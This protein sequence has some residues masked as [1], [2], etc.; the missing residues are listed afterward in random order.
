[1]MLLRVYS[2]LFFIFFK[3]LFVLIL[4]FRIFVVYI[5]AADGVVIVVVAAAANTV[6]ALKHTDIFWGFI[7]RIKWY[8][9]V[10]TYVSVS[11]S[12]SV[13]MCTKLSK[14]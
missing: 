6:T 2:L 9:F 7:F 14:H 5:D 8:M 4:Q 11:V 13:S 3:Y 1:M 12:V 10:Y